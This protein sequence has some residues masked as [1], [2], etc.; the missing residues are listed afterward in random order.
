M[1]NFLLF[2]SLTLNIIA[3]LCIVILYLRQNKLFEVEKKQAQLINEMEE[4]I[5]AYLIEMKEENEQFI[6]NVKKV[7]SNSAANNLPKKDASQESEDSKENETLTEN[8]SFESKA[9]DTA[10]HEDNHIYPRGNVFQVVQAYRNT[11]KQHEEKIDD[12]PITPEK[13]LKTE[14]EEHQPIN[15]EGH[16]DNNSTTTLN[17][18]LRLRNQG[19]AVSDIA[20]KLNKGKTEIELL[21]KFG[22]NDQE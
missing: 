5:S 4:I 14:L 7:Q 22:Q 16:N 8:I 12:L 20:K 10:G 15:K 2:I 1:T 3:F 17:E 19:H 18:A 21:L 6:K 13:D 11:Y 9:E